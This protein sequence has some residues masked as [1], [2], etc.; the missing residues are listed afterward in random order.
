MRLMSLSQ[1]LASAFEIGRGVDLHPEAV[2]LDQADGDVHA[3]LER[4]QLLEM[5]ALFE[6]APRQSDE[7]FE[8]LAPIGV[9]PD[10]FV[11]R[12]GTPGH[13]RLAEIE[14]A[15]RPGRIGKAG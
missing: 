3:R 1:Q 14:R 13:N 9:E 8:S 5:L 4:A 6:H 15:R 10:M 12:P 11:M 2:G 7:A